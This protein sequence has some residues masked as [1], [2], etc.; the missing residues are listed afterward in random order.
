MSNP[1]FKAFMGRMGQDVDFLDFLTQQLFGG[2]TGNTMQQQQQQMTPFAPH[3]SMLSPMPSGPPTN[4]WTPP[5]PSQMSYQQPMSD[6]PT[7][8]TGRIYKGM[9]DRGLPEHVAA[10]FMENMADE[11][12]FRLDAVGDSGNAKGLIQWNGP[13]KRAFE[14]RYGD[15]WSIDN[16]LDFLMHELQGPEKA[17]WNKISQTQTP[18]EAAA[19]IVNF[20]ERPAEEH[21]A[22]REAKY[23]GGEGGDWLSGST[24]DYLATGN[25]TIDYSA[26]E[27]ALS[28]EEKSPGWKTRA[29]AFFSGLGQL[30]EGE[31][32][33]VSDVFNEFHER[34]EEARQRQMEIARMGINEQLA[35]RERRWD[36]ADTRQQRAWDVANTMQQRDWQLSDTDEQRR[37][38]AATN[39]QNRAWE[40]SDTKGERAHETSERVATEQAN[41]AALKEQRNWNENQ[42]QKYRSSIDQISTDPVYGNAAKMV[43]AS[44]YTMPFGDAIKEFN[45][46]LS[47]D[48]LK[49]Y[50]EWEELTA[51]DPIAGQKYWDFLN[52]SGT[53][54][55]IGDTAAVAKTK[56]LIEG[57]SKR[58]DMGY[59]NLDESRTAEHSINQFQALLDTFGGALPSGKFADWSLEAQRIGRS[60]GF[61]LNDD[62]IA[63]QEQLQG[64]SRT[65]MPLVRAPGSQS[66]FELAD[67]ILAT[68]GLTISPLGNALRVQTM[69]TDL[70]RYKAYVQE[71]DAYRSANPDGNLQGFDEYWREKV[72]SGAVPQGGFIDMSDTSEASVD[73][74]ALAAKQGNL[75]TSTVVADIDPVT[76]EKTIRLITPAELQLLQQMAEDVPDPEISYPWE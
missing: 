15:D 54:I 46:D 18:G 43:Q 47:S 14:E 59:K 53:E 16:Q 12:G 2:A 38:E 75:S 50:Q 68:P 21:R 37:W 11:S 60:L 41:I 40:L 33:D 69:S 28:G 61:S 45:K 1:L 7:S 8:I 3:P 74:A 64:L 24:G 9:L 63:V 65:M 34:Q 25:D 76:N 39:L 32:I 17:A 13:R 72:D 31:T 62:N 70:N 27:K 36:V 57:A 6:R 29:S 35:Q 20:F 10:G 56:A 30:A 52:K 73:L 42:V 58:V 22:R 71:M 48:K 66:N 5:D 49:Q 4:V 55:N 44:G 23:L 67:N 26:M 51:K 19:A